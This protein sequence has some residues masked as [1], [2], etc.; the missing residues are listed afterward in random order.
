[1]QEEIA[2][3]EQVIEQLLQAIQE[4]NLE[5][6]SS[7]YAED[8]QFISSMRP[9]YIEGR[10]AIGEFFA[11]LLQASP[12]LRATSRQLSLK[13]CN[14]TTVVGAGYQENTFIDSQGQAINFYLRISA[15]FVKQEGRWLIVSEHISNLPAP[16]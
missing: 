11:G 7:A 3:V 6:I 15:T 10:E 4:R 8:A 9:F 16:A 14:A 2:E 1:M 5:V 13:A 12:T